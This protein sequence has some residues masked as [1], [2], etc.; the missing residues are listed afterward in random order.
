MPPIGLMHPWGWLVYRKDRPAP[1]P[2]IEAIIEDDW[3]VHDGRPRRHVAHAL[4]VARLL[5]QAVIFFDAVID[6]VAAAG[7]GI[8]V[9]GL[10]LLGLLDEGVRRHVVH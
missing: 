1:R 6:A 4:L 8:E 3:I 9:E 10:L 5:V 7:L 2:I